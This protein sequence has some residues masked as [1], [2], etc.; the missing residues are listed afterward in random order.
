MCDYI[1]IIYTIRVNKLDITRLNNL[2]F[3][4]KISTQI[5]ILLFFE[6][7]MLQFRN[8]LKLRIGF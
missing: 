7:F 6:N 8:F 5:K 3:L 2:K 4:Q 1:N